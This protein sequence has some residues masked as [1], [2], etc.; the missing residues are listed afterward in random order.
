MRLKFINAC[1]TDFTKA[2]DLG[3]IHQAAF[4][5]FRRQAFVHEGKQLLDNAEDRT[6]W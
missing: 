5:A 1:Q 6:E 3:V 2:I 4:S